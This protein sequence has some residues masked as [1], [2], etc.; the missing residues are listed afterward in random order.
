M[1]IKFIMKNIIFTFLAAIAFISV[2]LLCSFFLVIVNIDDSAGMLECLLKYIIIAIF[3][4]GAII[5]FK[6][7]RSI[8]RPKMIDD[9][10]IPK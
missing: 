10:N 9:E 8:K 1:K 5:T 6:Y 4:A 7:I 2:M 3:L